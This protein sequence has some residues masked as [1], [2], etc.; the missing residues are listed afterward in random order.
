MHTCGHIQDRTRDRAASGP[1]VASLDQ[2][3]DLP[4]L[5]LFPLLPFLSLVLNIQ[6][7]QLVTSLSLH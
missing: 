5:L 3:K 4:F 7:I 2:A 6:F 1:S